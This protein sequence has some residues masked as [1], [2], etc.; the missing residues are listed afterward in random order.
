MM[1]R[2]VYR[3]RRLVL[4]DRRPPT[5][6]AERVREDRDSMPWYDPP[7]VKERIAFIAELKLVGGEAGGVPP[8][9]F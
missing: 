2:N 5:L 9:W 1:Q 6:E 8:L 7:V 4:R 3:R